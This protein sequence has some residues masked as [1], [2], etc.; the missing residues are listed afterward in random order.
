MLYSLRTFRILNDFK[1]ALWKLWQFFLDCFGVLVK[2]YIHVLVDQPT[3]HIN[4]VASGGYAINR[5]TPS[6]F[7]QRTEILDNLCG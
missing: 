7:F 6:S 1:T 5:A 3:V 4:G 2:T